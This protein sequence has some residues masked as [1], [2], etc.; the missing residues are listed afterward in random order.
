[1]DAYSYLCRDHVFANAQ[2]GNMLLFGVHLAEGDFLL[3]LKYLL[4]VL[5]FTFGIIISD[6]IRNK[7]HNKKIHWRQL[8]LVVEIIILFLVCQIPQE[9][10]M[11][12]NILTSLACGV[13]VETF[14]TVKGNAIATTMCIG[15]L[16]SGTNNID[17]Y[18]NTHEKQYIYKALVYYSV[19]LFF[20]IGAILEGRLIAALSEK[21]L[22]FSVGLLIVSFVLMII[23]PHD[24]ET[25]VNDFV[26]D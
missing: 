5:A 4:P 23:N 22:Y 26:G 8:A 20:V 15:N 11:A 7:I 19:I 2:T 3:A 21:A 9:F 17:K 13:Q 6:V 14:R 12:A 16:R 1:M 18:I 10:N 25:E 24:K